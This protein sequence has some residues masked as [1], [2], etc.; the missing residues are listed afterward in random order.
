MRTSSLSLLVIVLLLMPALPALSAEE[1]E[2]T[3]GKKS[4]LYHELKPSIV[5]NM[6]KGAKYLRTDIQ[7]M[8]REEESLGEIERHA[9]ALRHEL[10][11]LLSDQEGSQLKA[12][13]G[14]ERFRGNALKA[15]QNVMLKITG[16]EMIE[17]L[18]F[19]SFFVQ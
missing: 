7:L 13:K 14:K 1:S 2:A 19:R 8:T 3:E 4:F 15:L 6:Q 5:A 9:P 18:Y 12:P 10:F 16:Q 11:L 17:E